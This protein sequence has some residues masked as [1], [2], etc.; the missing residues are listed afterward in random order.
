MII[1]SSAIQLNS[2]HTSLKH[3]ERSESLRFWTTG[4]APTNRV[5]AN[6][7][8]VAADRLSLSN[9]A[10]PAQ[11]AKTE[12]QEIDLE[13][14]LD[15]PQSLKLMIIRNMV[16]A[17]TGH[18]FKLMSPSELT[19]KNKNDNGTGK[20][21]IDMPAE[22]PAQRPP[23]AGFGLVYEQRTLH[24]ESEKTSFS[25]MGQIKTADGKSIDFSIQL[26]M[27]REFRM[28]TSLTITAGDP[29][30][31]DPLV[32]NF[33]GNAAELSETRF[34]F[35]LDADGTTEQI[36]MLKPGSGFLAWDKNNDGVINDGSEL[37]GPTTGK[38]FAE[39]AAHDSDGNGFIDEADPI[40]SKLRIWQRYEDGSEQLIALGDKN[41]G[42]IYLGHVSTPFQLRTA[43]NQSLG[44][45]TDTGIYLTEDGKVGTIQQI[46][47][48]V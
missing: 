3:T 14:S 20:A 48:S 28:E 18:D 22:P 24:Q 25:A 16:K 33:N 42:A 21:T 2:Q 13:E 4:E 38:G 35:D 29:E 23:S 26:N 40:Y 37:F 39:L 9:A 17:M 30:K 1:K 5:N 19:S 45:I 15:A 11:T 7:S 31:I 10:K 34:E 8:D 27:S 46:D 32:I 12:P 41:I 44:E 36:A 43:D 6:R 47:L